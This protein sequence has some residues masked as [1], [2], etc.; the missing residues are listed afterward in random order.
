MGDQESHPDFET[1]EIEFEPVEADIY[2][3]TLAHFPLDLDLDFKLR[4]SSSEF[5]LICNLQ[6]A[7]QNIK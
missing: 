5:L 1:E 7:G 2:L 3:T 6:T 4:S